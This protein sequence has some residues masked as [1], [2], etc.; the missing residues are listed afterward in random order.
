MG[1]VPLAGVFGGLNFTVV[2]IFSRSAVDTARILSTVGMNSSRDRLAGLGHGT[3]SSDEHRFSTRRLRVGVPSGFFFDSVDDDVRQ[4]IEEAIE[5]IIGRHGRRVRVDLPGAEQT[6]E[7]FERIHYPDVAEACA[8]D[9]D[10]RPEQFRPDVL[11]RLLQGRSET[12]TSYSA[13]LRWL[14][15]WR[16]VVRAAFDT[17]DVIATPVTP[18]KVPRRAVSGT[19]ASQ[20]RSVT[21]LTHAWAM[22]PVAAMSVPC[23]FDS[24]GLPVG[25]LLVAAADAD[26]RLLDVGAAYQTLTDWHLR[27]PRM[28]AKRG[29]A[30]S[31]QAADSVQRANGAPNLD[32]ARPED[33]V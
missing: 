29:R 16:D 13:A 19:A 10:R 24:N 7:V 27:E 32:G 20:H 33:L 25:L 14:A 1:R 18:V 8:D 23:G 4:T 30:T 6:H 17:A 5:I 21:A 22:A 31:G 28:L 2:G 15:G 12:A 9:I 11:Q 26:E 3:V